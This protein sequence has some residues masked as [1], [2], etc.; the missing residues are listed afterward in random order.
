MKS[1][2]PLHSVLC[3]AACP[4]LLLPSLLAANHD[5]H[6]VD[7]GAPPGALGLSFGINNR[8]DVVGSYRVDGAD[9]GFLWR[10]EGITDIG[11]LGPGGAANAINN[12]EE[13]VGRYLS[14]NGPIMHSCGIRIVAF[15]TSARSP[16]PTP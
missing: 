8:G 9:H 6:V 4:I 16:V 3:R 1:H 7:L 15:R 14:S 12:R 13:V 10:K 5:Y 2:V 11:V